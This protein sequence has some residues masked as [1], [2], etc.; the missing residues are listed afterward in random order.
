MADTTSDLAYARNTSNPPAASADTQTSSSDAA[1][2]YTVA[3]MRTADVKS[4]RALPGGD[5][6]NRHKGPNPYNDPGYQYQAP[7]ASASGSSSAVVSEEPD[8]ELPMQYRF[9]VRTP[10]AGPY[11]APP[12][13]YAGMHRWSWWKPGVVYWA[14]CRGCVEDE[15]CCAPDGFCNACDWRCCLSCWCPWCKFFLFSLS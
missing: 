10:A 12:P 2:P 14:T 7:A 5:V 1:R 9:P 13:W 11:V 8:K 4:V 3:S 15:G 6:R